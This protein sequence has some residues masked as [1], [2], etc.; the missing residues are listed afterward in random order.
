MSFEETSQS[1]QH[2]IA[3]LYQRSVLDPIVE[4]ARAISH[5][6]VKRPRHYRAVPEHV[7]GILEGFRIR[8]GSNPEWLSAAQRAN[9]FA[10]IFGAAFC[11]ISIGLRSASLAFAERGAGM[12]P[13]LLE[14]FA[15]LRSHSAAT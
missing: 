4:V 13:D 6:F 1:S 10:P 3:A 12:N 2:P 11:S 8:T 9:L 7:A 14:G 5:D 15:M